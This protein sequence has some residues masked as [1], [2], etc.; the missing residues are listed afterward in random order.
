MYYVDVTAEDLQKLKGG[1]EIMGRLF[2]SSGEEMPQLYLYGL[3]SDVGV[4]DA[5]KEA[6]AAYSDEDELGEEDIELSEI[7]VEIGLSDDVLYYLLG[8]GVKLGRGDEFAY[9]GKQGEGIREIGWQW[10]RRQPT[11]ALGNLTKMALASDSGWGDKFLQ[12]YGNKQPL[13]VNVQRNTPATGVPEP[14]AEK[15]APAAPPAAQPPQP[16]QTSVPDGKKIAGLVEDL[17]GN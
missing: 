8:S 17:L 9:M 5:A 10:T 16:K 13:K 12:Q 11:V 1:L 6:I 3:T 7:A 14:P 2:R 15:P 4:L